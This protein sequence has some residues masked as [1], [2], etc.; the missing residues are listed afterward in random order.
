MEEELGVIVKY[1]RRQLS[2]GMLFPK[3]FLSVGMTLLGCWATSSK[4][5]HIC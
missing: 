1:D 4:P 3:H 2:F 5:S